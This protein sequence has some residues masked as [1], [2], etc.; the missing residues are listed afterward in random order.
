[1]TASVIK[2]PF[3]NPPPP[4]TGMARPRIHAED[5]IIAAAT[6]HFWECGYEVSTIS[7]LEKASGVT[8][9]TI[10]NNWGDKR[11]LF[12]A[13]LNAYL[14]NGTEMFSARF[15]SN[16]LDEVIDFMNSFNA[17]MPPD[18]LLKNGCFL[19]ATAE[20]AETRNPEV[21]EII[22]SFREMQIDS[23][24]TALKNSESSG[25]L[26]CPMELYTAAEFIV[27]ALWGLFI[28]MRLHRDNGPV[29]PLISGLVAVLESWKV[30]GKKNSNI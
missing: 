1:M 12:I 27:G 26:K 17:D 25:E 7:S 13:A 16:G 2:R 29:A 3:H 4:R 21:R 23:F 24:H 15:N 18:D 8:R 11:G 30:D 28:T 10:Y 22:I 20:E 14:A 19:V 5:E 6:A 9:S